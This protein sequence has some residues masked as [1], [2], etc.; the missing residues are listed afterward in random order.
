MNDYHHTTN[1]TTTNA[2]ATPITST[3]QSHAL[4][5]EYEKIH[6]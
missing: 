4:S 5:G 2:P 1:T 6:L 3:N